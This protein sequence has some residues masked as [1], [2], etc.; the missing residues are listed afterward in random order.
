MGV[1]FTLALEPEESARITPDW[2]VKNIRWPVV[3]ATTGVA[4][5][6]YVSMLPAESAV[7]GWYTKVKPLFVPPA[8]TESINPADAEVAVPVPPRAGKDP[9]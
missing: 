3:P 8:N 1:L 7:P 9:G 5:I 6:V 4:V 2:S